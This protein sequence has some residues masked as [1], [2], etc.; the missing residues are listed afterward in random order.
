M[1]PSTDRS[2]DEAAIRGLIE[3]W[4]KAVRE[5]NIDGITAEHAPDVLMFDVPPPVHAEGLEA[6]RKTWDTFY[7]AFEGP[8]VFDV[9]DLIVAAGDDVAFATAI[10]QCGTIDVNEKRNTFPVRL[11]VGLRETDGRWLIAHEHHSVPWA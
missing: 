5:K 4:A 2:T 7:S 10:V 8:G 3:Q 6:Y 1:N 9:T 11:T